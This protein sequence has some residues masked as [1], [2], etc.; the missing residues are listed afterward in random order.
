MNYLLYFGFYVGF[1]LAIALNVW[2]YLTFYRTKYIKS[3]ANLIKGTMDMIMRLDSIEDKLKG[4]NKMDEDMK[5]LAKYLSKKIDD[6]KAEI[7]EYLEEALSA[8]A[9]E[10]EVEN[11]FESEEADFKDVV[12]IPE[13][14][15]EDTGSYD[16]IEDYA[17]ERKVEF[18]NE[19]PPVPKPKRGLFGKKKK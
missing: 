9:E 18:P 6:S 19:A 14:P 8:E 15:K 2:I 13:P 16:E 5:K 17:G 10:P 4:E 7:I 3:Q 1:I 12:E 11:D